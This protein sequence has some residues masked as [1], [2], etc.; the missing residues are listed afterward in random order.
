MFV[1]CYLLRR[2]YFTAN[3]IVGRKQTAH[4]RHILTIFGLAV[5]ITGAVSMIH[6]SSHGLGT[7]AN[8]WDFRSFGWPVEIWSRTEHVYQT[9]TISPGE[10]KVETVRYPTRYSVRWMNAGLVFAGAVAAGYALS[11][12]VFPPKGNEHGQPEH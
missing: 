1:A 6:N 11:V 3:N 2:N 12:W 7:G 4:M 8:S 10:R 5:L 9:V